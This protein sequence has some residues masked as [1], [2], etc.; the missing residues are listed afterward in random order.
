MEEP[1]TCGFAQQV[2]ILQE[3]F[4]DVDLRLAMVVFV[5]LDHWCGA[6]LRTNERPSNEERLGQGEQAITV[7]FATTAG[8]ALWTRR[9]ELDS[10]RAGVET[11]TVVSETVRAEKDLDRFL[12][13]LRAHGRW[14]SVALDERVGQSDLDER[15][16]GDAEPA[17]L[18]IDLAQEVYREVH[19]HSL[20]RSAGADRLAEVH[21]RRQVDAGVVHRIELGGGECPSL[22]GT[23]LLLHRVL[24]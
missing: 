21:V 14:R 20:D 22:G 11:Q 24:V 10:E 13:G 9:S 3:P 5:E 15:L 8:A 7:K 6:I 4:I 12:R 23:L 18:L 1:N 16:S 19:V 2:R 17:G